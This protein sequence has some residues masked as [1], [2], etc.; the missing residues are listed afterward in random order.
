M[1]IDL[2]SQKKMNHVLK[3]LEGVQLAVSGKAQTFGGRAKMR[4]A[5]HRDRGDA[6]VVVRRGHVDSYVIL[7]DE[8]AM[9]IEFGHFHNVTGEWVEGLYIITGATGL[10]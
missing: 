3:D 6:K 7:D 5:P 10:I 1:K 9:S 2:D 4:L 8:A